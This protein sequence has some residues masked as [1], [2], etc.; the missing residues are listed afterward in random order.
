MNNLDVKWRYVIIGIVLVFASLYFLG[1]GLFGLLAPHDDLEFVY[2]SP[3][4]NEKYSGDIMIASDCYCQVNNRFDFVHIGKT[5]YYLVLLKDG[6]TAIT[7]KAK[8]GWSP[9]EGGTPMGSAKVSGKLK[10]MDSKIKKRLNKCVQMAGLDKQGI[11]LVDNYYIDTQSKKID[12]LYV[13][14]GAFAL[15]VAIC[16]F[17][18]PRKLQYANTR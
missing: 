3:H 4:E 16:L 5:Y 14:S 18:M 6:N 11:K 9:I 15:I 2:D 7:V 1:N 10:E 12:I 13:I 8:K 17:I